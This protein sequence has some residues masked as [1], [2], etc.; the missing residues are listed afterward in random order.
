[1]TRSELVS[2]IKDQ[3]VES[4]LEEAL[5]VVGDEFPEDL[6]DRLESDFGIIDEE[7]EDDDEEEE[8]EF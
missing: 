5:D 1:M 4:G 8:V 3:I 6:A 7:D 2:A